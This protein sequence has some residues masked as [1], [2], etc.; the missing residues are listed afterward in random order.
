VRSG[1]GSISQALDLMNDPFVMN[2][3]KS[4]GTSTSLLPQNLNLPND[5]L[6]SKLYMAVLSRPP[7]ATELT[8]AV[9]L[10]ST[11]ARAQSAENLL[12]ALYNKVDFVF[13]Y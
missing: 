1:D 10:L 4:T 2:R 12:W 9:N 3:V 5:Q 13:N 6:V 7:S 11:G 8:T